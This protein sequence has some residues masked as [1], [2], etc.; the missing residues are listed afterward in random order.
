MKIN[1]DDFL[2]VWNYQLMRA[3]SLITRLPPPS[4]L[5]EIQ[6]LLNVED[7]KIKNL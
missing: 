2:S 3:Q 7:L 1:G 5:R 4:D 6:D